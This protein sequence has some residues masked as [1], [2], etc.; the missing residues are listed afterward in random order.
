MISLLLLDLDGVVVIEA[1]LPRAVAL[2]ILLLHQ[3]LRQVVCNIGI[4]VVALTHRSRV[5]AQRILRLA[6]LSEGALAGLFAAEDILQAALKSRRRWLLLQEGLRKSWVLAEVERLYAVPR[7]NI[8]FV[9]DQHDNLYDMARSGIGLAILAPSGISADG[10]KLVSFD[11]RELAQLVRDWSGIDGPQ[12]R[13]LTSQENCIEEWCRTGV[14]TSQR[15]HLFGQ[16]RRC[17]R[18]IRRLIGTV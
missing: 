13:T 16:A 3:P 6:G 14:G 12:I 8:A 5:E 18:A 10:S 9:D 17:G 7:R 1:A 15:W 11:F 4:P 2:E